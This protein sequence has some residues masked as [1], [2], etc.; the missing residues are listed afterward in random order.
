MPIWQD[1]CTHNSAF[2]DCIFFRSFSAVFNYR[3]LLNEASYLVAL[4]WLCSPFAICDADLKQS[5]TKIHE[6]NHLL[7]RISAVISRYGPH[8]MIVI[9]SVTQNNFLNSPWISNCVLGFYLF[10]V[11]MYSQLMNY[12]SISRIFSWK[13][14]LLFSASLVLNSQNWPHIYIYLYI[15]WQIQCTHLNSLYNCL[16]LTA[17]VCCERT[18]QSLQTN[19]C[20]LHA[21]SD[22]SV[23]CLFF[24]NIFHSFKSHL[25]NFFKLYTNIVSY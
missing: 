18:P 10:I 19:L 9:I 16:N 22:T 4:R 15:N 7:L 23:F 12:L 6:K 17:P 14:S 25:F 1:N 24:Q 2:S 21:S 5:K 13:G 3:S 20:Q 8:L 11:L